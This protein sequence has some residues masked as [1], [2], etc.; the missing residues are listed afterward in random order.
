MYLEGYEEEGLVETRSGSPDSTVVDERVHH[1][2]G[3]TIT[4]RKHEAVFSMVPG[5]MAAFGIPEQ[6]L[7]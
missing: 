5:E 6:T 7:R 4:E 3:T 1:S 2:G